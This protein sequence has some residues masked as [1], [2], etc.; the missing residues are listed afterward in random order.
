MKT[1]RW[2]SNQEEADLVDDVADVREQYI[3]LVDGIDT[4]LANARNAQREVSSQFLRLGDYISVELAGQQ[5]HYFSVAMPARNGEVTIAIARL[6]G[7]VLPSMF[8]SASSASTPAA[9]ARPTR[10]SHDFEAFGG[11]ISFSHE[12]GDVQRRVLHLLLVGLGDEACSVRIRCAVRRAE[13]EC[14]SNINATRRRLEEK[15]IKLRGDPAAIRDLVTRA[16]SRRN[17]MKS[18]TNDKENGTNQ[19]AMVQ[20]NLRSGQ[21]EA[22]RKE[23]AR[24]QRQRQTS[25]IER[26]NLE[27]AAWT[28]RALEWTNKQEAWQRIR[29]EKA[30]MEEQRVRRP[31]AWLTNIIAVA[32]GSRLVQH[33][34]SRKREIKIFSQQAEAAITIQRYYLKKWSVKRRR[35]LYLSVL[36]FRAGL[37]AY[38]RHMTVAMKVMAQTRVL[39]LLRQPKD[40]KSGGPAPVGSVIR[41]FLFYVRKVQRAVRTLLIKQG[42][43]RDAIFMRF[44]ASHLIQKHRE[45][46]SDWDY[47]DTAV[48]EKTSAKSPPAKQL[49]PRRKKRTTK[50]ATPVVLKEKQV[51]GAPAFVVKYFELKAQKKLPDAEDILPGWLRRHVARDY[52]S[53]MVRSYPKRL[54]DFMESKK[55]SHLDL[56]LQQMGLGGNLD[57]LKKIESPPTFLEIDKLENLY[58]STYETWTSGK[59]FR[60]VEHNYLRQIGMAWKIWYRTCRHLVIPDGMEQDV[61]RRSTLDLELILTRNRRSEYRNSDVNFSA[62]LPKGGD[63]V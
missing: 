63:D 32:F 13:E 54:T 10:Q 58:S 45:T 7:G 48:A 34:T 21:L 25:A 53:T 20:G 19:L 8:A 43:R 59:G 37:A 42:S 11:E 30:L 62:G 40:S 57:K 2:V 35:T 39:W 29:E 12:G 60:E 1:G 15:L 51:G 52:V 47:C 38:A 56:E 31:K 3:D 49:D 33:S 41:H 23:I 22:K 17:Q 6:G 28:Q 18:K 44:N 16:R 61:A 27:D 4:A 14:C 55:E 24:R 9:A 36:R 5:D 26:R 50:E 46:N